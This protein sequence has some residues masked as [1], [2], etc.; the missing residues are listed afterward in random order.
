MSIRKTVAIVAV[1]VTFVIGLPLAFADDTAAESALSVA[2]QAIAKLAAWENVEARNILEENTAKF[3][4]TPEYQTAWALLEIQ[5]GAGGDAAKANKALNNLGQ[6]TKKQDADAAA[7]FW[8]GEV[9]YQKNKRQEAD[10]AWKSAAAKAEKA[11]KTN[12]QDAT[13]Q[14]YYGASLIRA[15]QYSQAREALKKASTGGF[16]EA[17]VSHQMGLSYLF[18]E[19][20][21]EAKK[22]FNQ[23]LNAEPRFAP[24]YF[25]RAMAWEKLGRKDNMLVDLDQFLKLAPNA[26]EASKAKAILTSAGR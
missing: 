22:S 17:M 7:S 20:W 19:N 2:N 6:T 15:K 18:Q 11:V 12:P 26:P 21:Q 13:A 5:E 1:A 9:L 24:M 4:K 14:F 16:D 8:Q 23:G 25:W 3:G 10:A